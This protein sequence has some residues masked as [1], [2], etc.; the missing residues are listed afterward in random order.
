MDSIRSGATATLLTD[1]TVLVVGGSTSLSH[2]GP[3]ASAELFDP[4][5]GTWA[6]T[7]ELA[8]A[9]YGHVAVLLPDATVLVAGG[10]NGDLAGP[11]SSGTITSAE[12]YDPGRLAHGRRPAR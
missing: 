10:T 12:R 1:G 9:R 4:A 11:I 5:R 2:G 7:G 8:D 6:I 3:V